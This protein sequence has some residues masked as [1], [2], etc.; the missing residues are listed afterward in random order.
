MLELVAVGTWC[1]KN[2][3]EEFGTSKLKRRNP[4]IQRLAKLGTWYIV[5]TFVFSI[6]YKICNYFGKT[7]SFKQTKLTTKGEQV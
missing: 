5:L 6:H 4:N 1:A 3:L 7:R 2:P